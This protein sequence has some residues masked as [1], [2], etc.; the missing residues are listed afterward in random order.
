MGDI[1]PWV[2]A[3]ARLLPT[4]IEWIVELANAGSQDP[5]GEVRR[6]IEDRR[7]EIAAKRAAND[8]ALKRKHGVQ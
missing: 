4:I 7:A 2:E 3:G 6:E 1:M 5:A 8:E